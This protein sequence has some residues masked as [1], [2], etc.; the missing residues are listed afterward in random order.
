MLAYKCAV[1]EQKA[2]CFLTVIKGIVLSH[3]LLF[4]TYSVIALVL[5]L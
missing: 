4:F 2:L 5:E 3:F 1:C